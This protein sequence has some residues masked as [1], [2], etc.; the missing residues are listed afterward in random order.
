[1]PSGA[2]AGPDTSLV[3]DG[4]AAAADVGAATGEE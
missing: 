4:D 1:M 2:A 3:V